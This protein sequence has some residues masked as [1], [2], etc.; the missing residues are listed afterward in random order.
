MKITKTAQSNLIEE[1]FALYSITRYSFGHS[2]TWADNARK[3]SRRN[4][5]NANGR[6]NTVKTFDDNISCKLVVSS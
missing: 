5:Q 4:D 6:D 1:C 2:K 3:E